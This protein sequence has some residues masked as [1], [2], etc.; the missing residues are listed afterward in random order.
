MIGESYM[1]EA[2]R[3]NSE[4]DKNIPFTVHVYGEVV[5]KEFSSHIRI[6][7]EDWNKFRPQIVAALKQGDRNHATGNRETNK[8]VSP[9][10]G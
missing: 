3:E 9:A 10:C 2:Y 5:V 1:K 8:E 4:V 7:K 6:S